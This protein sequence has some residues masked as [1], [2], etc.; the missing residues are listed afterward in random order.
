M[1]GKREC[2]KKKKKGFFPLCR[3]LLSDLATCWSVLTGC[4][5]VFGCAADEVDCVIGG[6]Y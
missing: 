5:I 1:G 4:V 3:G 6:A 2:A